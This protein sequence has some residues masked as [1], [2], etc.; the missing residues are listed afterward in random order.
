[1]K[2]WLFLLFVIFITGCSNKVYM[3]ENKY[4][5]LDKNNSTYLYTKEE[6]KYIDTIIKL[7][8]E[9][10]SKI[11]KLYIFRCLDKS[12]SINI[13]YYVLDIS[14]NS[15][16]GPYKNINELDVLVPNIENIKWNNTNNI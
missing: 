13:I 7:P 9:S 4:Y 15:I 2:K 12:N 3:L 1:M 16:I 5:L 10:Y 6:D 8:I 14:K 11:D